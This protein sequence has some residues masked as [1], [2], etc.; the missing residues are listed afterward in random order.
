MSIIPLEAAP[1][2]YTALEESG[3]IL[4]FPLTHV[5]MLLSFK[6]F[7]QRHVEFQIGPSIK[8]LW[9]AD[10]MSEIYMSEFR[11]YTALCI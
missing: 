10:S 5:P 7:H 6:N 4:I 1:S 9:P 3:Y 2:W 11:L 8:S